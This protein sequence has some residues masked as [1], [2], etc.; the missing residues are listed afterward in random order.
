M[1]NRRIFTT[2][3]AGVVTLVP[4][5]LAGAATAQE[6]TRV[7]FVQPSPSAIN[8]FNV[9]VAIGEGYFE[10]EGLEVRVESINGS[11]PVL[12]ALSSGQAQFG[13]PGPGPVLAA[14]GRD[15]DVVFIY[16]FAARSN[17]G[18]VVPE[19]S[20]IQSPAELKGE[21]VGTGTADGAEV[22]FARNVLSGS[23]LKEG[24]DY[25]FLTVGD[26]GPAVAAFEQDAIA[27]YSS[28]TADAAILNQ[29]GQAVRDITPPEYARFFGNGFITTG[30]LIRSNPE[31]VEKFVR[32]IHKGHEFAL[33]DA[34]RE[35][36]LEHM[37]SGNPQES[38]DPAFASALFDAV[39][40]KTIPVDDSKG[41]GYQ[42][43]E[44]WEEWQQVLIDG[45]DLTGPLPDL[46]AAYTNDFALKVNGSAN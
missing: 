19:D 45:G 37:A 24:T 29:R 3:M 13:R 39:R 14:R 1:L 38:E 21:V 10:E 18:I 46:T 27:A 44:V 41:L 7:T 23:G 25:R 31:L 42:P 4:L 34:N 17:F 40:S 12:Q 6:L 20:A 28:S 43:P 33:D 8:S 22:G 26:G 5:G 11:G 36:V 32:A 16:N 2:L 9:F 35:K 30:E 15:V